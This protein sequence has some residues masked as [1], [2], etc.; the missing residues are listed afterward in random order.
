[1]LLLIDHL[2][3]YRYDAPVRGVVQSHR[4]TPSLHEGQQV[5]DWQVTVTGGVAGGLVPR[6]GGGCGAKLDG[7]GP[8]Q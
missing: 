8:G 2:T 5:I 1:M 6:R 3:R 4:L 7:Q